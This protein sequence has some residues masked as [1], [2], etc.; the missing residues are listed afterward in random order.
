MTQKPKP[1]H[2]YFFN[3]Q[4][5]IKLNLAGNCSSLLN[6]DIDDDP[7]SSNEALEQTRHCN[8]T[9]LTNLG[10]LND[11]VL[12]FNSS[13]NTFSKRDANNNNSSPQY[14]QSSQFNRFLVSS[15]LLSSSSQKDSSTSD[16]ASASEHKSD[17]LSSLGT[18]AMAKAMHL[19]PMM[20]IRSHNIPNGNFNAKITSAGH[21][22][23]RPQFNTFTLS[24]ATE[25]SVYEN[26]NNNASNQLKNSS[27]SDLSR[28][29]QDTTFRLSD[30]FNELSPHLVG[31]TNNMNTLPGN[32]NSRNG[33]QSTLPKS[34]VNPMSVFSSEQTGGGGSRQ[35]L[36][37]QQNSLACNQTSFNKFPNPFM[38]STLGGKSA[39][40]P[41]SKFYT[42]LY[43]NPNL[44]TTT[45]NC[46]QTK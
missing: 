12:D 19:P 32:S 36:L 16:E 15:P 40:S 17:L 38:S 3:Q 35:N 10:L 7:T 2:N 13:N 6:D 25:A 37:L 43:R 28:M 11:P 8:N 27:N 41:S 5:I 20:T 44:Q 21:Q 18:S 33:Y 24:R 1:Y 31:N 45:G 22:Q 23:P 14:Y 39:S 30:L 9:N 42:N 29:L 34:Q 26:N 46:K 4:L